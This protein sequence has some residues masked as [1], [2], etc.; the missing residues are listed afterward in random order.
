MRAACLGVSDSDVMRCDTARASA[1]HLEGA[2]AA[3]DSDRTRRGPARAFRVCRPRFVA[4]NSVA[5]ACVCV[6]VT[7]GVCGGDSGRLGPRPR[8]GWCQGPCAAGGA[9]PAPAR[10]QVAGRGESTLPS[11]HAAGCIVT[12]TAR[13]AGRIRVG[14]AGAVTERRTPG[15]GVPG[16]ASLGH[17]PG[18]AAQTAPRPA[19]RRNW[20]S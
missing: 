1:C 20:Q 8:P 3:C 9:R 15:G 19:W 11:S 6:C 12:Q 10:I 18:G 7:R 16:T 5:P 14:S 13:P 17:C 4:G 2:E